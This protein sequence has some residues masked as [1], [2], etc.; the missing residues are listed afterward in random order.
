MPR[1]RG[2]GSRCLGSARRT[3]A[4]TARVG[5]HPPQGVQHGVLVRVVARAGRDQRPH[6][7]GLP[8]SRAAREDDGL[9]ANRHHAGVDE[10]RPAGRAGR[11]GAA[12]RSRAR[13]APPRARD[14]TRP[15]PRRP[16][17]RG[18]AGGRGRSV[19]RGT[20]RG[21]AF[22]PRRAAMTDRGQE[23]VVVDADLHRDAVGRAPQGARSSRCASH[24]S[25]DRPYLS[26][27]AARPAPLLGPRGSTAGCTSRWESPAG[28][29]G[30]GHRRCWSPSSGR[31]RFIE[32]RRLGLAP[33]CLDSLESLPRGPAGLQ[34][35]PRG[36]GPGADLRPRRLAR[37]ARRESSSRSSPS[38]CCARAS[39]SWCTRRS[40]SSGRRWRPSSP[41]CSPTRWERWRSSPWSAL[42]Y[43]LQREGDEK[44]PQGELLH[45]SA[46]K[47]AVALVVLVVFLG[48]AVEGVA[49]RGARGRGRRCLRHLLRQP[50]HPAGL[51][52]PD[53]RLPLPAPQLH[54]R[55]RLPRLG[56]RGG[57]GAD[58]H[59]P[60]CAAIRQRRAGRGSDAAR[61]GAGRGVPAD[62][63]RPTSSAARDR[64]RPTPAPLAR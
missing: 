41:P 24:P 58:P 16:R 51:R 45:F 33:V 60:H 15:P 44:L 57:D 29:A 34:P 46:A 12:A 55:A 11:P 26:S 63:R 49:A 36:G 59:R 27:D 3:H 37:A 52:R 62:R 47:E 19:A 7:G 23:P 9:S 10:D 18:R 31:W 32:L 21:A 4:R 61:R 39:R 40:P 28:A 38:S 8:R 20:A 53:H 25:T 22:H 5:V 42:F 64:Q 6:Q 13:R 50:L 30:G 2:T 17:P 48:L 14:P 56:L 35:A 43:R 54:L 1:S